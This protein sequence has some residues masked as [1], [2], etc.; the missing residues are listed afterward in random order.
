[1]VG[2][3]M[4]YVCLE[5]TEAHCIFGECKKPITHVVFEYGWYDECERTHGYCKDHAAM[6]VR[7]SIRDL[8][9]KHNPPKE[10][11]II[12]DSLEYADTL[13]DDKLLQNQ[14]V[15]DKSF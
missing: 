3:Y 6:V 5:L 13:D 2:M 11:V 14:S 15:H 4:P 9:A 8:M 1:M 12:M 10:R 7:K